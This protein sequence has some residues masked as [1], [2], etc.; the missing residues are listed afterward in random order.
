VAVLST[1]RSTK[2]SAFFRTVAHL[3]VQAAEALEHAHQMGVIHRDIKPANLLIDA[4]GGLWVADFGLAKLGSEAGLTMTGDLVGTLRYMSPEQALAKRVT[5]DAR[6]DVYSLGVTL[7]ELLTM[8]PAYNG[9]NREE[10]LRQ[11]AFEEPRLPGRLNQAVPAELETIV[12]KAMAKNPEERYATAQ[13]LSEDMRRYLEDKPI[14]A[15]R[16]S[17]RLRAAKWARRHKTVVRAAL[18]VLV[19]A[20]VALAVSTWLI[21]AAYRAE[22]KERQ[23]AV[24]ALYHSY[25]REAE[26]IRQARVEVTVRKLGNVYKLPWSW[27]HPRRTGASY[28]NML[29]LAW[30]T[31]LDS[32]RTPGRISQLTSTLLPCIP[33][34]ISWRSA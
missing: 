25:V 2:S 30:E 34:V 27:R 8:E 20:M 21:L 15:K 6:T 9:R 12:M 3:G 33:M 24:A 13:E 11:I 1:E 16:P 14:K 4:T 31:L 29:S 32:N 22:A 23:S 10:V 28:A 18:V 19:L 5:V 26:T 17:L 7:Y